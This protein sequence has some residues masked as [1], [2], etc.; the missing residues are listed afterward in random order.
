M[1]IPLTEIEIQ[2]GIVA[3]EPGQYHARPSL[4]VPVQ[5]VGQLRRFLAAEPVEHQRARYSDEATEADVEAGDALHEAR[6]ALMAGCHDAD[7]AHDLPEVT[8]S[9]W[10]GVYFTVRHESFSV[11]VELRERDGQ[12]EPYGWANVYE[13]VVSAALTSRIRRAHAVLQGG[14]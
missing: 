2:I 13:R 1:I 4:L 9:K 7:D 3:R 6:V 8:R 5:T 10:C 14:E 11:G 12:V